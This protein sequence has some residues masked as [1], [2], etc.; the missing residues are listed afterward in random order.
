MA[1]LPFASCRQRLIVARILLLL[2]AQFYRSATTEGVHL[3]TL[4]RL[5]WWCFHGF[6]EAPGRQ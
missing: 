4:P 1:L 2:P 3:S 5:A 6:A